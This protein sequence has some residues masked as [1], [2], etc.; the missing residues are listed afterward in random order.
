MLYDPDKSELRLA[1]YRARV[2][3]TVPARRS[4]PPAGVTIDLCFRSE[5]PSLRK[6]KTARKRPTIVASYR[7]GSAMN[8]EDIGHPALAQHLHAVIGFMRASSGW[9]QF[10]RLLQRAF[11]KKGTNLE[12]A[13]A[14]PRDEQ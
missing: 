3:A 12:L 8:I 7:R 14:E 2:L 13:L 1:E 4:W 10:Y 11:P 5:W 9:G 6:L